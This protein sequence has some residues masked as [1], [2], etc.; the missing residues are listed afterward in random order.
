MQKISVVIPAY[1]A[2]PWI[3]ESL[4][5]VL[6]QTWRDFEV[7]VIDDGSTDLTREIVGEIQD[8]RIRLICQ[9]NQ[10][11]SA[12]IN[13]GVRESTGT[14]VKILDAD[15]WLNPQHLA[16]QLDAL[17]ESPDGVASCRWG[18]FLSCPKSIKV[19]D[20]FTHHDYG[21]PLQWL[22]DSLTKDQ[23]MMGGWMWLIPRSLWE[24]V[25][26]YDERL[27]LN[28]DFDFSIRLL[29]A[30]SGVRFAPEAIYGYRKGVNGAL[31]GSG[32]RKAMESAFKTTES[33]CE[34]LLAHE[35]SERIRQI[36]ADRW[37]SWLFRFYPEFPD[38]ADQAAQKVGELGGSRMKL[39]GGVV[40]RALLPLLGWKRVR[41]LQALAHRS[42]WKNVLR[43]KAE[44]RLL[45]M[46]GSRV[47]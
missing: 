36:C 32:G 9:E 11:Q 8:P 10:G 28:N 19:E 30:S 40:L 14:H 3:K 35:P 41:D 24:R 12:A 5:S 47:K 37:Q 33:G 45:R 42:A 34:A 43:W 23:G 27:S 1:N 26:G 13:R 46:A 21:D 39:E 2:A 17:R 18:Y 16:A 4:D 7:V 31:S 44:R 29:L 38:L 20:E 15:D 25:G 22:V 6:V